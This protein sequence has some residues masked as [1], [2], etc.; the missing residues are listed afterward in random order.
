MARLFTLTEAERILPAVAEAVQSALL[1]KQAFEQAQRQHATML[2]DLSML[3]G[4]IPDTD[5]LNDLRRS[6]ERA[7]A[8]LKLRIAAIEEY[9]CLLKDLDLGLIDFLTVYKGREVCLCW[10]SGEDAIRFWHGADEGYR[11]RKPIDDD[12]IAGHSGGESAGRA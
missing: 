1:A 12:F 2:R 6:S 11:G 3:G 10:K 9:G 4:V 8:G 7:L 5:R